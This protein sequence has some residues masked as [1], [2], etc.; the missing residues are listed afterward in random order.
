MLIGA[1]LECGRDGRGH[2]LARGSHGQCRKANPNLELTL[3]RTL[4]LTLT[5][6]FAPLQQPN[7][8]RPSPPLPCPETLPPL[9]SPSLANTAEST[10]ANAAALAVAPPR[11]EPSLRC[12]AVALGAKLA[13][14][15]WSSD[16]VKLPS[17]GEGDSGAPGSGA[18]DGGSPGLALEAIESAVRESAGL[19]VA[20]GV[21]AVSYTHLTLP[22]SDLV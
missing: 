2:G 18:D 11:P 12:H 7:P 3:T 16:R 21:G 10:P 5:T 8:S 6:D 17:S 15:G 13:T 14:S 9:P 1:I 4:T 22:T 20:P 19:A